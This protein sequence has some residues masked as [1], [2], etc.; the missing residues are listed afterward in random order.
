MI[1]MITYVQKDLSENSDDDSH[2]QQWISDIPSRYA[3]SEPSGV[4]QICE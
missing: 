1:I 2:K 4:A 3:N